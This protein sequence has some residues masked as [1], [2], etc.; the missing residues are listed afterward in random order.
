MS[1]LL[2]KLPV[3]CRPAAF[4]VPFWWALPFPRALRPCPCSCPLWVGLPR[5]SSMLLCVVPC[6]PYPPTS[7]R[8]LPPCPCQELRESKIKRDAEREKRELDAL[9]VEE[10]ALEEDEGGLEDGESLGLQGTW[11][12]RACGLR[13]A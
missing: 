12:C 11:G 8:A 5:S 13:C 7:C 4:P 6:F 9:R 10:G 3:L 2:S 1:S